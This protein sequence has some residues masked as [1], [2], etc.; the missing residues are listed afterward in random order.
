M[1]TYKSMVKDEIAEWVNSLKAKNITDWLIIVVVNDENKVKSKL[2][3][4]SVID[5]VR[6]DFCGKQT[7]R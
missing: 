6:S 3:R 7:E 1:D 5:S 4:K 2:L